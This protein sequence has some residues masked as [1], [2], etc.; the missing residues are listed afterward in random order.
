[1]RRWLAITLLC[2]SGAAHAA[3]PTGAVRMPIASRFDLSRFM[4]QPVAEQSGT[5]DDSRWLA[6]EI[7]P[8]PGPPHDAPLVRIRGKKV[9]FRMSF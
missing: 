5:A 9:K 7:A 4:M 2:G 1:M 8:P 3:T 6:A